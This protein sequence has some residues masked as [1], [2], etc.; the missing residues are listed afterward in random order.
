[1]RWDIPY[2][3]IPWPEGLTYAVKD[4]F[5]TVTGQLQVNAELLIFTD[6]DYLL[7]SSFE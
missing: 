3:S 6:H 5:K 2:V 1:M 4:V 7:A